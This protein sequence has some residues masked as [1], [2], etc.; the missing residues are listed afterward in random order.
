MHVVFSSRENE[1]V[2]HEFTVSTGIDHVSVHNLLKSAPGMTSWRN[3]FP[4]PVLPKASSQEL[5]LGYAGNASVVILGSFQGSL[6]EGFDRFPH[7]QDKHSQIHCKCC[8]RLVKLRDSASRVTLAMSGNFI[9]SSPS[10]SRQAL[11]CPRPELLKIRR[12]S[13]FRVPC[14]A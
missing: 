14:N 10:P 13:S 6:D 1:G 2:V 9:E 5:P 3:F 8:T 12:L 11:P 4:E 7:L